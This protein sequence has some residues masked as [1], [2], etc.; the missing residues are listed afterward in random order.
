LTGFNP[1]ETRRK[2]R[3]EIIERRGPERKEP[4]S[5]RGKS[6]KVKRR[7]KRTKHSRERTDRKPT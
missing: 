7:E 1:R 3:T 4:S 6:K 5:C 2:R